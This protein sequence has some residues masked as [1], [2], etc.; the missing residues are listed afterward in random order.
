M[1]EWMFAMRQLIDYIDANAVNN[2]SLEQLSSRIGYST[3]H[4]S[5][6]FHTMTGTTIREYM[7]KRKLFTAQQLLAKTDKT[8]AEIALD[9]GFSSQQAFTRSF[10]KLY[11]ITPAAYRK[12]PERI[13][14]IL[15]K[16]SELF[17]ETRGVFDTI[18]EDFERYR[19]HYSDEL[20]EDLVRYAGI[21]PGKQVL[22]L[23]PGTGQ[24]TDPILNTGCAYQA[25]ELGK[26][27]A[28]K[29]REK[30]GHCE[31]FQIIQDDFVTHDFGETKYDMIYSAR[32]IQW[33]PQEVAF[34]KTF[35]LLKPGGILAMINLSSDFKTPN[36]ELFESIQKVYDQHYRPVT[37]YRHRNFPYH[38]AVE[39]GYVDYEKREYYGTR[40]LT[41]EQYIRMVGTHSDHITIP[42]PHRTPFFNGLRQ[43]VLDAGDLIEYRD[44]HILML[45]RKP[46]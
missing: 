9:C 5:E 28:A 17:M 2:P 31:N 41:A 43:A 40:K 12:H 23:G 45:A 3:F 30:Y 26:H 25:I 37:Q 32:T 35:E 16:E 20:F 22:E 11:G 46:E 33:I 15:Q 4:C 14:P 34:T 19:P 29:M 18:A 44:T 38:S 10:S 27:L 1:L 7:A 6:K 39:Y 24:A 36:P 13:L 8:I 21:G 42:E